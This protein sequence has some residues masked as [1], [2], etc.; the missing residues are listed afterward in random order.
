MEAAYEEL[1]L[2]S[3]DSAPPLYR[4]RTLDESGRA[5]SVPE[6]SLRPLWT[7]NRETSGWS[8]SNRRSGPR[9]AALLTVRRAESGAW[10]LVDQTSVAGSEALFSDGGPQTKIEVASAKAG[11]DASLVPI[12]LVLEDGAWKFG[13]DGAS[14]SFEP[15]LAPLPKDENPP[16]KFTRGEKVEV[17]ALDEGYVGSW[18]AAE[19]IATSGGDVG[20]V[21]IQFDTLEGMPATPRHHPVR[22]R[23]RAACARFAD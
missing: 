17:G 16:L 3:S 5:I 15:P 8:L 20:K 1:L 9:G 12:L 19:I 21:R 13:G 18:Y 6:A 2:P 23:V 14:S 11:G 10:S 22:A 4:V 7:L